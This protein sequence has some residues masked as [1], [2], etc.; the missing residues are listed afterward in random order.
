MKEQI[1]KGKV[2]WFNTIKG[3][4]FIQWEKNGQSQQDMFVH[5]SDISQEGF[6]NLLKDQEVNFCL[7]KNRND[8]PKAVNVSIIS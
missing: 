2:V 1:F 6:K 7:G 5:F 8:K 3:Y 4:G